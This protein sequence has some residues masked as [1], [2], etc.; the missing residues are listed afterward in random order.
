MALRIRL[1]LDL[2]LSPGELSHV[3]GN[4]Q[5][6]LV[7]RKEGGCGLAKDPAEKFAKAKGSHGNRCCHA[8]DW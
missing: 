6:W 3:R 7:R 4:R 2:P 5:F 1:L 8:V